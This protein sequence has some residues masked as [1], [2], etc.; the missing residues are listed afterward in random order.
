M[1]MRNDDD[2]GK[3]IL[4]VEDVSQIDKINLEDTIFCTVD[5]ETGEIQYYK[6]E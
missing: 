4:I 3:K 1:R 2:C 6:K 5:M